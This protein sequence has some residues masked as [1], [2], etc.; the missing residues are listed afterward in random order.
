MHAHRLLPVCTLMLL[1]AACT[2]SSP[3]APATPTSLFPANVPTTETS[4]TLG[5]VTSMPAS[6]TRAAISGPDFTVAALVDTTTEQMTR[7]QAQAIIEQAS[8]FLRQ[9][10]PIGLSMVD[11]V[12]DPAG[13]ST[14]DMASRYLQPQSAPP[15]DGIVIFSSGDQNQARHTGGYGYALPLPAGFKNRFVSPAVGDSQIYVAVVDYNYRYMACGY[16]GSDTVQSTQS[17]P[18]ECRGQTGLACVTHNGYSMCSNAVGNLYTSTPTYAVSS[19]VVH[20]LLHNFGPNGDQDHYATPQCNAHMGYPPNFFDLQ[21]SEYYNG[22][23]PFV[24]EDF[25]KAFQ[26]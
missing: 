5:A 14:A 16:G 13:G 2:T 15:P 7:E 10:S 1:L 19:I 20:G 3:P 12:S 11:F 21:E 9:F 22:L 26:R 24:S 18:G 17:L 23:C 8:G 4:P 6:A 25:T